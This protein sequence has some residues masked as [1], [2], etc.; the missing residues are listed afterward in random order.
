MSEVDYEKVRA[1]VRASSRGAPG[2]PTGVRPIS[3]A[4][5]AL[6]GIGPGNGL[7]WDGEPI[8]IDRELSLTLWQTILATATALWRSSCELSI[9]CPSGSGRGS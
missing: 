7:Y 6:L 4:G 1:A 2:W 8:K 9:G 3:Q 5:L